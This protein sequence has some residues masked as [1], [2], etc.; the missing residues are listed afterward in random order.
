MDVFKEPLP[1][2]SKITAVRFCRT[3]SIAI[4]DQC[5]AV[6]SPENIGMMY[7]PFG[8]RWHTWVE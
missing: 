4:T 8:F 1:S 6:V 5:H 7:N 2:E 3:F